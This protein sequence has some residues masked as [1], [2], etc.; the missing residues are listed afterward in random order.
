M[1]KVC[2]QNRPFFEKLHSGHFFI[3]FIV[4]KKEKN[5]EI[6][7]KTKYFQKLKRQPPPLVQ[8]L[9][10]EVLG[11]ALIFI[12]GFKALASGIESCLLQNDF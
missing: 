4:G 10:P 9:R 11:R 8:D 5:G 1:I 6:E 2:I 3:I 7:P 12:S